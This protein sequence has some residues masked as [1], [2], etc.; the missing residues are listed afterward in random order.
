M[1]RRA[2]TLLLAASV[3]GAQT[4]SRTGVAVVDPKPMTSMQVFGGAQIPWTVAINPSANRLT[5]GTCQAVYIDLKDASGK[6]TP[7]NPTGARVSIAD[8]DWTATSP[9]GDAVVGVYAGANSWSVCACQ[10]AV[11]ST[12]VTVTATYPA[13][14]INP[15]AV[16][17]GLRFKSYITLPLGPP[18]GTS[19][20][21]GC[22]ALVTTTVAISVPPGAPT[23]AP[24][25][26]APVAI[27]S[28]SANAPAP[29]NSGNAAR[30]TGVVIT[31][32]PSTSKV[33]W[34]P[35]VGAASY[36]VGR[37]HQAS[38]ECC[39]NSV[40]G[41]TSPVWNDNTFPLSGVYVYEIVAVFPNGQR[42]STTV[43]YTRPEPLNPTGLTATPTGQGAVKLSW[44][45][46]PDVSYYQVWGP[47]LPNTGVSA[48]G[49]SLSV[50]GVPA[51]SQS[52][53][54]GSFYAPPPPANSSFNLGGLAAIAPAP[55]STASSMFPKVSLTMSG[56]V[57]SAPATA[58]DPTSGHYRVI[59]NGFRVLHE[60][61]DDMF[62][63]DG[64]G[65][66]VYGAFLMFHYD[67]RTDNLL[68]QDL[69]RTKVIGD[70]NNLPGRIQGGRSSAAGGFQ[71][72]DVFPNVVD[73]SKRYSAPTDQSFP[74]LI[75][76]GQLTD[77]LDAVILL[78]TLWEY[79]GHA[80][81]YEKWFQSELAEAPRIYSDPSV[82]RAMAG[83][84]LAL[85]SPPGEL[86][87]SVGPGVSAE[88]AFEIL[89]S[90]PGLVALLS[91]SYDRPIGVRATFQSVPIVPRRAIVITREIIEAALKRNATGLASAVTPSSLLNV[92]GLVNNP[93][94]G[95]LPYGTLAIPLFDAPSDDLQGQYVLYIQVERVP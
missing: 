24:P 31:G 33:T 65:D 91:G 52:W 61:K 12:P 22:D 16:V 77:G 38:P 49:A 70:V 68:D 59:A 95:G 47:G 87:T 27:G 13:V 83:T 8:F 41:L 44:I 93:N 46:V 17:D 56:A 57:A 2:I 80:D 51:G 15:K 75:W 42:T 76:D 23:A 19:N 67:R 35:V 45:P 71:A 36:Q 53:T 34:Q 30:P 20:P 78:P 21:V 5:I 94:N 72:G 40:S 66:E 69:R 10:A 26:A 18:K 25:Q 58:S 90:P 73:P 7:R 81:G 4:T 32:S 29:G 88:S 3:A 89:I 86:V 48:T 63:R 85:I 82:K 92:P 43:N 9:Q 60:T 28:A 50:T 64:K 55:V 62:S 79:D 1:I 39:R 6:E 11:V 84:E 54:V 74:L 14:S 37:S